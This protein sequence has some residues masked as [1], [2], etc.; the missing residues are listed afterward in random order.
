MTR[1]RI[2]LT[3][4]QIELLRKLYREGK[5]IE[6]HTVEKTQD[7]LAEELG[8]TRQALSNHLKVLKELGYIRTGRGFIDLTDKAL[9]LLGEKRGD[10]FIFVKIEPTKRKQVYDTIK[11]LRVKRIYRVTGD[12]DLIIEADKSR[13]D[14]ILEEIA[15]LDGVKETITH[16][17]LGVL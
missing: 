9:E 15:A 12:I 2:E 14:E 7:E 11:K 1:D 4:R 8:I 17:V 6:V 5:T 13:L 10:V 3:N 16:V